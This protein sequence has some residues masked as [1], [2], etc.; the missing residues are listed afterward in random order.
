VQSRGL[1]A[2]RFGY[3]AAGSV[4][5]LGVGYAPWSRYDDCIWGFAGAIPPAHCTDYYSF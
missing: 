2:R 4:M 3:G 1:R 5:A